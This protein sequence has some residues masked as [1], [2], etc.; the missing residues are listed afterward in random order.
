MKRTALLFFFSVF[1]VCNSFATLGLRIRESMVMHSLVL[2]QDVHFSVCL[3]KEY[4]DSKKSYPVVYLLHGLGDNETSWLEY[5]QISQ[6]ADKAVEDEETKPMIFVMPE[7]FRTYYV[8]DYKGAF[9]YQDMFVKELVPYIDS[10]FRTIADR[11]HR[12]VMGYS[13]GGFGTP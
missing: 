12:A 10:L 13:M 9:L 1:L 5:G 11:Q 7:A 6:Y 8:N 4:Y 3:P 2:K